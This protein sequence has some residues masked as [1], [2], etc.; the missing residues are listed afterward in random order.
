MEPTTGQIRSSLGVFGHLPVSI[1]SL[2]LLHLN[3]V[4]MFLSCGNNSNK[5][6]GLD[7]N[8]FQFIILDMQTCT[9]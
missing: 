7:V 2:M 3:F 6:L 1:G 5:Y 4:I 8:L 9:K